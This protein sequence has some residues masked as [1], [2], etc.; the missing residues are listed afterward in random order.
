M[1]LVAVNE[2]GKVIGEGHGRAKLTDHDI[3]LIQSLLECREML[4]VEYMKVGL[5]RGE[6]CRALHTA[7]LSYKGIADKFEINKSHV[8]HIANGTLRGQYAVRWKKVE[9]ACI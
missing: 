5:T 9:T 7:Q 4:I 8:R 1:K 3:E 6:V 2:L